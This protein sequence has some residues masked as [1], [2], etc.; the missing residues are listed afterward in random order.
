MFLHKEPS[1]VSHRG[2]G[3]KVPHILNLNRGEHYE[4]IPALF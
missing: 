2:G 4:I 1:Y 3:A